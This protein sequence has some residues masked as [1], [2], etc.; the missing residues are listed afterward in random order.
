VLRNRQLQQHANRYKIFFKKK[1]LFMKKAENLPAFFM[2]HL[3]VIG[4]Y[5][6]Q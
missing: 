1:Q 2:N 6:G 5:F 4:K 3:F